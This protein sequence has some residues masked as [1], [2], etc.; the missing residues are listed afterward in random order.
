MS[1][2]SFASLDGQAEK[3]KKCA[4]VLHKTICIG[5]TVK[6]IIRDG[7]RTSVWS[8]S[9]VIEIIE[10][11]TEE[12]TKIGL[13]VKNKNTGEQHLFWAADISDIIHSI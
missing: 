11:T 7:T 5:D 6:V 9:V 8:A 2:E 13:T 10:K 4:T 3:P 12:G 1:E